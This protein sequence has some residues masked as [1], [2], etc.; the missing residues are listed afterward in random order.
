MEH[1]NIFKYPKYEMLYVY[2]KFYNAYY[3]Q[4]AKSLHRAP[5]DGLW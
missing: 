4:E 1:E 2:K 5:H 3:T